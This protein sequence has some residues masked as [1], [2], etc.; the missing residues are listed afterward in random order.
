MEVCGDEEQQQA[1]DWEIYLL[2]HAAGQIVS[3]LP[4][5][6]KYKCIYTLITFSFTTRNTEA[7]YYRLIARIRQ[8]QPQMGHLPQFLKVN[9]HQTIT[10]FEFSSK[11]S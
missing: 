7:F 2:V 10:I 5:L 6:Q 4:H 1:M 8:M 11:H 3:V 9:K